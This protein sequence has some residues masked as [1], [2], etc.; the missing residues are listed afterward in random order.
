M[1]SFLAQNVAESENFRFWR[2]VEPASAGVHVSD[3]VKREE[4][5]SGVQTAGERKVTCSRGLFS[6][7]R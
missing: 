3:L 7:V 2:W 5:S 6:M 1:C 4:R